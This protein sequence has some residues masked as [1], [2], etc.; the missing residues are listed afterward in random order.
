VIVF[1][2]YDAPEEDLTEYNA[3]HM[4]DLAEHFFTKTRWNRTFRLVRPE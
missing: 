1:W 2:S 4:I 3:H